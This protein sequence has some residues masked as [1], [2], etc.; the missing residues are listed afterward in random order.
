MP[1][2]MMAYTS[3]QVARLQLGHWMWTSVC[4]AAYTKTQVATGQALETNVLFKILDFNQAA[5]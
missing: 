5:K 3:T 1:Y 2:V 4:M